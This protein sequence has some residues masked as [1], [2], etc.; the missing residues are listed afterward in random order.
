MLGICGSV[1]GIGLAT[2]RV[3][4]DT[5]GLGLGILGIVAVAFGASWFT[6]SKL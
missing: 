4:S 1:M 3:S 5:S 6:S 2:G